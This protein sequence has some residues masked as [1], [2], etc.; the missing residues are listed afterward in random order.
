VAEPL[1]SPQSTSLQIR[2]YS[3]FILPL[4][5]VTGFVLDDWICCTLYIHTTRDYRRYSG[6]AILHTLQFTVTRALGYSVVTSRIL[7][8]DL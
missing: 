4:V 8:T 3:S 7:A 5:G 2:T 1:N 6:T